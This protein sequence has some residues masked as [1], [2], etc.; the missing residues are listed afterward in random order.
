MRSSLVAGLQG[1]HLVN[2]WRAIRGLTC[3]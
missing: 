1:D 3:C 2:D